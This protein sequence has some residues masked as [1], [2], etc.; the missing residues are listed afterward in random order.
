MKIKIICLEDENNIKFDNI[1]SKFEILGNN[2]FKKRAKYYNIE[3]NIVEVYYLTK[4]EDINKYNLNNNSDMTLVLTKVVL[5]VSLPALAFTSFMK[6]I[7]GE[8]LKQGMSILV[9]GFA[10]YIAVFYLWSLFFIKNFKIKNFNS[11]I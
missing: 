11:V 1:S 10:I 6:D 5:T 3:K 8:Q 7:N 2:S 4:K 9:W